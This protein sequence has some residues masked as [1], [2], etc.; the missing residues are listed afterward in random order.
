M[1]AMLLASAV[2][3]LPSD[4]A[5]FLDPT[6]ATKIEQIAQ[7][8]IADK[9]LGHLLQMVQ[10]AA[11]GNELNKIFEQ[12]MDI[13]TVVETVQ[14][15]EVPDKFTRRYDRMNDSQYAALRDEAEEYMADIDYQIAEL[16]SEI[17]LDPDQLDTLSMAS[18]I[19]AK[20]PS[21][22][23]ATQAQFIGDASRLEQQRRDMALY[24]L[25]AKRD[26][27]RKQLETGVRGAQ[28]AA[29]RCIRTN[30]C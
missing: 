28:N 24:V 8:K 30:E 7:I 1:V 21:D 14:E 17:A 11:I 2:V 29:R 3:S 26:D 9:Q 13:S 10:S 19:A 18:H 27:V 5:A 12:M 22:I 25:R 4:A 16:E 6:K 15:Y 23:T 20:P